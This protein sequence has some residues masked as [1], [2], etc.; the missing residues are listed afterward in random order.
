MLS[1]YCNNIANEYDIKICGVNKLFPN[2][3]NKNKYVLQ[4]KNLQYHLPLGM[5]LTKD[6]RV[7]K[8]KQSDR[9]KKYIG[10]NTEKIKNATNSFGNNFLNC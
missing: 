4:Y 1:S 10:F 2:L 8:Y 7:L 9:L 3:G 6:H 5:K